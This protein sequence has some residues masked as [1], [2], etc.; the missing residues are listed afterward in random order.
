MICA[1]DLV[2]SKSLR[3]LGE[4]YRGPITLV[5]GNWCQWEEGEEK[6]FAHI[7]Y[8]GKSGVFRHNGLKVGLCHEDDGVGELLDLNCDL[9]VHG[10]T[11]VY[12]EFRQKDMVVLCPG[13]IS[14]E[15][16]PPGF[17]LWEPEAE[18]RRFIPLRDLP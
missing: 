5:R 11:H 18:Y 2:S 3:Y 17:V 7:R 16:A 9:G 12:R 4:K 6:D 14:G 10:H 8:L 13:S 15:G 1:G